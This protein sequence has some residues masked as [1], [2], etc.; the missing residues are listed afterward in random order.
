MTREMI[1]TLTPVPTPAAA[2][3]EVEPETAAV[4]TVGK[5]M[6][7][8]EVALLGTVDD[9]VGVAV[10]D[11]VTPIVVITEGA[12]N[13]SRISPGFSVSRDSL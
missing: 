9:E 12:A 2:A 5:L 8:V 1:A 7:K 3:I 4:G 10:L 6:W 11:R 13:P